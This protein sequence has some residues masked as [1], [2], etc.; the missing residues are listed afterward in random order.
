[1]S[2]LPM[3][4]NPMAPNYDPW[5]NPEY[6]RQWM[7]GKDDPMSIFYGMDESGNFATGQGLPA[8]TIP[9]FPTPTGAPPPFYPTPT[10][11]LPAPP[12]PSTG[13]VPPQGGTAPQEAQGGGFDWGGL[14]GGL[15]NAYGGYEL[16]R[17][18]I[19][20]ARQV[21]AEGLAMSQQLGEEAANRAEF[22]PFTVTT[23]T[24][25]VRTTPE[26]GI[27]VGL[28]RGQEDL[29]DQL[30]SQAQG[31]FGKV[32]VDPA[33]AQQEL[34]EQMRAVQRPE[35]ERKRLAL[36][37]RML[38]QGRMGLSSA[39][40]GGSSPELLAQ[41]QAEQEAMAKANLGA[42]EQAMA[43]QK[44]SLLGAAGLLEGGYQPQREV[45]NA[46]A[47]G[48]VTAGLA[49]IGRRSGADLYGQMG[50]KGIESYLQGAELA[51]RLEQQQMSGMMDTVLGTEPTSAEKLLA[52]KLGIDPALIKETG[53]LSSLG[54]GD[55][56]TPQW[57]KELGYGIGLG[58]GDDD[59]EEEPVARD[60]TWE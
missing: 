60:Y 19:E 14:F 31:L 18:G 39:A 27:S 3:K 38:S 20:G 40:Y 15:L 46:L 7:E 37:E 24:G 50:A 25:N 21:G 56:P 12:P 11:T 59:E 5:A 30:L 32:G 47:Q 8:D 52:A 36:E 55:A 42:R 16:G 54:Y 49:D 51:S 29:R 57:I 4:N 41:A 6:K 17:Q 10:G 53:L 2:T 22:Q 1:M 45:L 28:T 48:N 9:F 34:Y 26:G 33:V 44:Q 58:G 13:G 23:G 35:E 43:E